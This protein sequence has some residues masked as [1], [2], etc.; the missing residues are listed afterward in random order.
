MS[1]VRVW[2]AGPPRFDALSW[3][4]WAP[5]SPSDGVPEMVAV[6]SPLLTQ[7][8]SAGSPDSAMAAGTGKPLV[9][10]LKLNGDPLVAVALL[11]LV[12]AGAWP[13][14]TL[15]VWRGVRADPV[16]G[17]DGQ[18]R[19]V[20]VAVGVPDSRAVPLPLSMKLSPAG[21]LPVSVIAGVGRAGGGDGHRPG[22]VEG[23]VGAEPTLV[24]VGA[25]GRVDRDGQGQR[26]R[27]ARD[28]GGRDRHR[29]GPGVPAGRGAGDGRRCRCRCR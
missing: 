8:K 12:K 25:G 2:V 23:E 19:C 21:R 20:P 6:P 13:T 4:L 18:A 16:A 28:V 1:R 27:A 29:V 15:K 5:T 24:M 3:M 7:L 9:V 17:V 14:T 26:G 11:A 22:L 10:T